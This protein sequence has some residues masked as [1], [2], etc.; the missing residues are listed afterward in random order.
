[1]SCIPCVKARVAMA[2]A[3]REAAGGNL[4]GAAA[5]VPKMVDALG[6][7]AEVVRVRTRLALR[8]SPARR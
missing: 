7:K 5:Q 1:M 3:V 2:R 4:R 8:K 6:E